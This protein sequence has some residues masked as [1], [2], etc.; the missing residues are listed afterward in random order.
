MKK[1]ICLLLITLLLCSSTIIS[2]AT[3]TNGLMYGDVDQDKKITIADV[4]EVQLYIAEI[5]ELD[6]S[7]TISAD[8]NRDSVV[9]I[10]DATLI[11]LYLADTIEKLPLV[12]TKVPNVK[13]TPLSETEI[14]V[15][16]SSISGAQKYWV[17]VNDVVYSAY[18]TNNCIIENRKAGTTYE[19]YVTALIDNSIILSADDADKISVKTL[20]ASS[21]ETPTVYD[22]ATTASKI[23]QYQDDNT[24]TISL[25]AD[26][27][28]ETSQPHKLPAYK[29]FGQIQDYTNVDFA[30]N[31]GDAINGKSTKAQTIEDIKSLTYHTAQYCKSPLYFV[32][33][34]HDDNGWYSFGNYGGTYKTD[35][36]INDVE[37][38]DLAVKDYQNGVVSDEN[39]PYG[40]YGYYD[41]ID[42]KTRIFL[43]NTSDIPYI[44]EDDGTYRYNS[45]Q[46]ACISN[47]QLN[48]VANALLF[49]DKENPDEWGA[50][51]LS[52]IPLDS[53][54]LDNERFGGKMALPKGAHIMLAIINAYH[55]GTSFKF[56]GTSSN[57]K[58]DIPEDFMVDVDVDYSKKGAG[59]V[60]AFFSGHTHTDNFCD[61]VSVEQSLSYGF[62]YIGVNGSYAFANFIIDRDKKLIN[63]VKHGGVVTETTE[64]T[65]VGTPDIGTIESGEWAVYYGKPLPNGESIY[66]GISENWTSE[67]ALGGKIDTTT[68]ELISPY[69]TATS[70]N[71]LT[72]AIVIKPLTSYTIPDDFSG[73]CVEYSKSGSPIERSVIKDCGDYKTLQ[74][75]DY[76]TYIVFN[77][78]TDEYKNYQ[79]FYLKETGY[80]RKVNGGSATATST[81]ITLSWNK[82]DNAT[83]YWVY[84]NNLCYLSTTDTVCTLERLSP[85]TLY[86][87]YVIA[88]FEDYTIQSSTLADKL[89]VTTTAVTVGTMDQTNKIQLTE[90]LPIGKYT[91]KYENNSGVM[92]NCRDICTLDVTDEN[93]HPVYDSFIDEN[94]A[95]ASCTKIGVYNAYNLKVGTINLS[96]NF[97][98]KLGNKLYSFSATSDVHL[99]YDTAED[100]FKLALDYFNQTEKVD[101]NII[102]GDLTVYGN[103]EELQN[104][105]NMVD[106]YSPN[107]EVYVAAGNHE[108]YAVNSSSY[109]EQYIGNPLYYYFTK[110]NDV[111]I[112]VGV[113]G[114]HE[115]NFFEDGEL[116]WLYEMLEANRNK[117]CFVFQ[118]IPVENSSGDPL[119]TLQGTTT[120]I[121]SYKTSVAFKNL[122][123]HYKNVIHFHGHTHFRLDSQEYD[124][125]ANYDNILGTHSVHISSL[126]N[127]RII[128]PDGTFLG[129]PESCEG[130]V[131]DVYE[132]GIALRAIDLIEKKLIPVASYYL[133][134]TLT[135]VKSDS[136]TDSSAVIK[137][138]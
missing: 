26:T 59:E 84:L 5:S 66:D 134:T 39:N 98:N 17:Y 125:K 24:L 38:Y 12:P 3:E 115:Y 29:D 61:T 77:F 133:D 51:F 50:L 60:I 37:W 6:E 122:L 28:F 118:H 106:L 56:S 123:S 43:L 27:H 45:Y 99:G 85:D 18:T 126:S 58:T 31:L 67:Y 41:D 89:L 14:E 129:S 128:D 119:N 33:G 117:R 135:D 54:N 72:K 83:K 107:T 111:F 90:D 87:I 86:E 116:Q 81:S 22:L 136:F 93:P 42:S 8:V 109:Y 25:M 53:S 121:A 78:N 108:E 57:K 132:N 102:C 55:K 120:K 69:K 96:D 110:G 48:F 73:T 71:Q 1:F 34:N 80:N 2:F 20:G 47:A 100:D 101:F 15:N 68:L 11:Q 52:H 74:T 131:V 76:S 21:P 138:N 63:A 124:K 130:Y 49:E 13:A 97:A 32:R 92:E 79:D 112:F 9:S 114:T 7:Q 64:G 16:W 23:S 105:R 82:T 137:T 46:D 88:G 44:V 127:P 40:G 104:F 19:I 36:I 91:L 95:P 94:I 35:E 30:A 65:L 4:T 113:L 62:T 103:E 75:S 70:N 10:F